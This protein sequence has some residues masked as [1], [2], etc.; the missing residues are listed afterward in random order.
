M[1]LR[2]RALLT[3][4]GVRNAVYRKAM[5]QEFNVSMYEEIATKTST[6]W[7]FQMGAV[8]FNGTDGNVAKAGEL[9]EVAANKFRAEEITGMHKN[10]PTLNIKVGVCQL[11]FE[12]KVQ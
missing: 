2:S 8:S 1:F 3:R 12:Y 9:I 10:F 6:K 11:G 5:P 7:K 4:V